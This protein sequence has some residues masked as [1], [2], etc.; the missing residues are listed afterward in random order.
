MD[1]KADEATRAAILDLIENSINRKYFKESRLDAFFEQCFSLMEPDKLMAEKAFYNFVYYDLK[2]L[3]QLV[4]KPDHLTNFTKFVVFFK[5]DED[6]ELFELITETVCQRIMMFSVDEL[7]TVLANMSQTLSP[8]TKEV[9]KVVNEEFIKR[10]STD[11]I[12]PSLDLIFKPEDLLK[13]TTT[14]LEYNQM[15]DGLKEAIIDFLSARMHHLT[16][17]TTSELA[18]IFAVRMDDNYKKQFFAKMIDKFLKELRY[19]K[20]ETLYKIVW[21]LVKS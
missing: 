19:L 4:N 21:S 9:F 7:L 15:H 5:V 12:P 13:V 2:Q 17:E 16:Y 11:Y 10:V 14:M 18:V 3:M 20:D 6:P 1:L 8:A